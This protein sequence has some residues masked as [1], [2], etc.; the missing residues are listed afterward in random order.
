M[1]MEI[2]LQVQGFVLNQAEV[3]RIRRQVRS[4]APRL[5]GWPDPKLNLT[6]AWDATYCRV[7]ASLRLQLGHLGAHLIARDSAETA[8]LVARVVVENIKRQLEKELAKRQGEPTFGVPSR[9]EPSQSRQIES[10]RATPENV[11]EA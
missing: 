5:A 2:K 1:A 7:D 4:L 8:D 6:L 3:R 9:R 11:A 10:G